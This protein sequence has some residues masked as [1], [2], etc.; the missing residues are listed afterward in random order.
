MV[1]SCVIVTLCIIGLT[2]WQYQ[3]QKAA[4]KLKSRVDHQTEIEETD[5]L[6]KPS[7]YEIFKSQYHRLRTIF[8]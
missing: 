8:H 4:L 6:E 1:I 3:T 5:T 2:L 7:E